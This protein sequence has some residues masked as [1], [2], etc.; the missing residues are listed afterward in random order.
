MSDPGRISFDAKAFLTLPRVLAP[1]SAN[2]LPKHREDAK[3]LLHEA[4]AR[5]DELMDRGLA[6][7]LAMEEL[8]MRRRRE[9]GKETHTDGTGR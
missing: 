2:E 3:Q 9:L 5:K 7:P 8:G 1:A 6:A 4:P